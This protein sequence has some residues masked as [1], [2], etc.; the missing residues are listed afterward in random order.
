M[1]STCRNPT[2]TTVVKTM[3]FSFLITLVCINF[4]LLIVKDNRIL[5]N[6]KIKTINL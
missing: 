5:D 4:F 6:N 3:K 2:G 1:K